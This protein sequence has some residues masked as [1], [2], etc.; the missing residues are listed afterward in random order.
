MENDILTYIDSATFAVNRAIGLMMVRDDF[1]RSNTSHNKIR[2]LQDARDILV[3]M[4]KEI[5]DEV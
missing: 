3:A 4:Y 5:S 1:V 2:A